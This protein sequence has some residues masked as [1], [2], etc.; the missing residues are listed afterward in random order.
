MCTCMYMIRLVCVCIY[1][2]PYVYYISWD[3]EQELEVTE[4][5][6]WK[7]TNKEGNW[8]NK[9]CCI[10]NQKIVITLS[11]SNICD[12]L[13]CTSLLSL[14]KSWRNFELA[15]KAIIDHKGRIIHK[16]TILV[17][18]LNPS[19]KYESQLGWLE[20]QYIWANK[21]HGNQTTNQ[22]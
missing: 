7:Q 3:N 2:Y 16:I 9:C 14:S 22:S 6:R 8:S 15:S 5:N 4:W 17:G 11:M 21:I 10:T 20:T 12:A 19:E 18:G 1:I 13:G